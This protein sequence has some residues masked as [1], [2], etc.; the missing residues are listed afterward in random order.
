MRKEISEGKD[1]YDVPEETPIHPEIS[2]EFPVVLM[3]G[4]DEERDLGL[5]DHDET[6]EELV[7][8]ASQTTGV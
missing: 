1:E 2:T 5:D 6:E 3:D 4:D 7:Q 8:W